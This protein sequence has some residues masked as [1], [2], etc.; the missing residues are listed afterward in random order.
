MDNKP[1]VE[2]DVTAGW[3]PDLGKFKSVIC[4]L[5]TWQN[6]AFEERNRDEREWEMDDRWREVGDRYIEVGEKW[7]D[8]GDKYIELGDRYIEVGD[9]YREDGEREE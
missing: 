7:I 3:C 2:D 6:V 9:S 5:T 1:V 8:L 4:N